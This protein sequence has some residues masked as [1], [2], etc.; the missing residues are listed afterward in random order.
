MIIKE[1]LVPFHPHANQESGK[2]PG[3]VQTFLALCEK[4]LCSFPL[5]LNYCLVAA[6]CPS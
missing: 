3:S 2:I 6:L 5:Y 4:Y 1:N